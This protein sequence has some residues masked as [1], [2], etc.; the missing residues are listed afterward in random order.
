MTSTSTTH[1]RRRFTRLAVASIAISATLAVNGPSG[2][3]PSAAALGPSGANP[4]IGNLPGW[5]QIFLDDFTTNVAKGSFPNAV[6]SKWGAYPSPWRDTS[7]NGVYSPKE[8]VYISNGALTEDIHTSGG[9]HKVA[10]LTPK[11]PGTSDY[12]QLYGRYEVRMRSDS[13]PGYKIAWMLWPDSGTTIT[14]SSS[15]VGGNGEIDYPEAELREVDHVWGFVHRQNATSGGDQ[16]WFKIPVNVTGWHTYTMEWSPNLVRLLL[17]GKEVGRT[18]ERIPRTPMHWVLQTE[19]SLK[20][21]PADSTRGNIQI[22]WAAAWA[23]DPSIVAAAP[24]PAPAPQPVAG[25]AVAVTGI[26][27]GATVSGVVNLAANASDASGVTAV[28]WYVDAVEV[29]YD[30]NG[31]PW[32]DAWDTRSVPNGQHSLFA[33]ARGGNGV[34]S[35]SPSQVIVV[36]N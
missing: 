23:Y 17:D 2:T 11:V 25:P 34:W 36:A 22:D 32:T 3:T 21:V 20:M 19:T 7:K 28:K 26:A 33:K 16:A 14:G 9:V 30:G 6:S 29:R 10:A 18:T 4:P 1:R 8:V 24:A 35:T 12:G 5:R 31:A 15:G 27:P 13:L